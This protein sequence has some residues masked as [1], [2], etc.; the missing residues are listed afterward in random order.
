MANADKRRAKLERRERILK[1]RELNEPPPKSPA[2]KNKPTP[3]MPLSPAQIMRRKEA[4]ALKVAA[5]E[6]KKKLEFIK[7]RTLSK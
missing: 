7:K 2:K 3:K 5:D 4:E 6:R 1:A